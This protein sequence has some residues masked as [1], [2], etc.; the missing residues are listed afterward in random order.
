ML[1]R[2]PST[3]SAGRLLC[4]TRKSCSPRRSTIL[5]IHSPSCSARTMSPGAGEPSQPVGVRPLHAVELELREPGAADV[6]Q[7]GEV[8]LLQ[9]AGPAQP[10]DQRPDRLAIHATSCRRLTPLSTA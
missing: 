7:P 8:E 9:P 5:K 6:G 2:S 1:V 3:R 10:P 4:A